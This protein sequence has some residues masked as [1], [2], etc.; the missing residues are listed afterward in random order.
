M[1]WRKSAFAAAGLAAVL[2]ISIFPDAALSGD[3]LQSPAPAYNPYP[4]GI[5]PSDLDSEIARVQR[6]VQFI[7]NETLNEWRALPPPA[8]EGNPPTLRDSGYEAVEILGKLLNFDSNM[9]PFR[10]EACGFCHMPYVA[11]SGPIPSVNLTMIGYPGT[12]HYRAGKRTAQRYTYSPDFPVLE[13]DAT[14]G[15]FF[16][17]NFWDARST[18]YKLQSADAE[19]AQHPPVDT[20]EMGFPDT[21]CIAFRLS[22][23]VYRPLFE[24]VWGTNFQIR[25]P[26]N[27]EQICATPGGTDPERLAAFTVMLAVW[28]STICRGIFSPTYR[29]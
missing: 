22:K 13:Y 23:A 5:L 15:A 20:Q 11:F 16:G 3:A 4:P 6:E 25:W 26:G 8:L 7:F 21:A 9:S 1:H 19:Q 2:G 18:G 17:G 28:S 24:L 10:N 12:L 14:Q 27:T 29:I